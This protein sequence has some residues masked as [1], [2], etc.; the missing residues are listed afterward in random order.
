MLRLG[1]LLLAAVTACDAEGRWPGARDGNDPPDDDFPPDASDGFPD[2]AASNDGG[3]I[4][5][6]NIVVNGGFERMRE[7]GSFATRWLPEAENPGG[8]ISI[9]ESP[10]YTGLRA[11]EFDVTSAG[12]GYEFSVV[13]DNLSAERLVPGGTYELSGFYRINQVGGGSINFNYI[14]RSNAGDPDIAND[15]DDDHPAELDTWEDFAWEFTIPSDYAAESYSLYLHF[16]KFTNLRIVLQVDEVSL[17][18]IR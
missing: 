3:P 14:L 1:L 8:T 9:V 18:Q 5:G 2:G 16:I 11:L 10:T 6:S 12:E 7:D 13:E 15:W 4:N 17:L